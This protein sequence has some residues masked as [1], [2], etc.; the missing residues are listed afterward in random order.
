MTPETVNP[1]DL[2]GMIVLIWEIE[3]APRHG[4]GPPLAERRAPAH[5]RFQARFGRP[6]ALVLLRE[7]EPAA[8]VDLPVRVDQGVGR[9]QLWL[10]APMR[11]DQPDVSP[12]STPS[13]PDPL[14][15]ARPG[16]APA[17]RPISAR[18]VA[19][20]RGTTAHPLA[21]HRDD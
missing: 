10:G 16:S 6:P 4:R 11:T 7:P 13:P 1:R 19:A 17:H 21:R 20:T 5:G 2:T 15:R 12:T 9:G 18:R 14:A 8:G 3:P